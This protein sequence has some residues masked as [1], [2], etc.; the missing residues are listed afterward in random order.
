MTHELDNMSLYQ[1]KERPNNVVSQQFDRGGLLENPRIKSCWPLDITKQLHL[2]I[3]P[4][5]FMLS[6]QKKN[7]N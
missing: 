7:N 1:S 5:G 3:S 2:C 6:H 4:H